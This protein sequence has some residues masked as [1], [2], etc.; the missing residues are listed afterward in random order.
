MQLPMADGNGDAIFAALLLCSRR[1]RGVE[2]ISPTNLNTPDTTMPLNL[3][4]RAVAQSKTKKLVC[5]CVCVCV[6][7]SKETVDK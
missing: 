4:S 2:G 5:V 6:C 3:R 7:I 1:L